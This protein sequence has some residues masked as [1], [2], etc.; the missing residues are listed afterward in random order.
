MRMAP[1][2]KLV[3][4]AILSGLMISAHSEECPATLQFEL[5]PLAEKTPVS[6]CQHKGRVILVVNTASYCGFTKQYKGLESL[7]NRYKDRGL[8]VLG[9]PSNDFWNQEPDSEEAIKEFCESTYQVQFPMYEKVAVSKGTAHPFYQQLA[10]QGGGYPGWNFHKYLLDRQ[11]RVI[12][13]FSSRITPEDPTLIEA[14][15]KLL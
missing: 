7:Y 13:S 2:T 15:E 12:M 10:E 14:I 6:L 11:G 4:L 3:C 1:L 8:V 9:F 5:R